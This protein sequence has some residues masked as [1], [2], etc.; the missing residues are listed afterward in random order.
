VWEGSPGC[1]QGVLAK[2]YRTSERGFLVNE[3]NHDG[4][5]TTQPLT[6]V[7][8]GGIIVDYVVKAASGRKL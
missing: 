5:H 2:R 7:D 3:I 4:V 1:R 8:I 6:G